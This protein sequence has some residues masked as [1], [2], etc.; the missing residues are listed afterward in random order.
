MLSAMFAAM[1]TA[2]AQ[3]AM[4]PPGSG[5]GQIAGPRAAQKLHLRISHTSDA[6]VPLL[7]WPPQV[8]RKPLVMVG[9]QLT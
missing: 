6:G 8:D 5:L 2:S 4:K 3:Q 1:F 9:K 7:R